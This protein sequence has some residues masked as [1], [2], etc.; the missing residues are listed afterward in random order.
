VS[1][2]LIEASSLAFG[3]DLSPAVLAS[4][5]RVVEEIRGLILESGAANAAANA[6]GRAAAP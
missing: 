3:L 1:V 6:A 5:D 2:Y 4:A